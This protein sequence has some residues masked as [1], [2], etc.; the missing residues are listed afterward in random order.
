[1]YYNTNIIIML[2]FHKARLV[3]LRNYLGFGKLNYFEHIN[4]EFIK[5]FYKNF[6]FLY[7]F[8]I[9]EDKLLK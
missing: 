7:F 2:A 8:N 4:K 6:L 3:K 5:P 9:F 1:M